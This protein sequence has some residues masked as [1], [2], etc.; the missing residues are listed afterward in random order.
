MIVGM[1]GCCCCRR[2]LTP[3]RDDGLADLLGAR[4]LSE[5]RGRPDLIDRHQV[6]QSSPRNGSLHL[7]RKSHVS[8]L[9]FTSTFTVSYRVA[10]SHLADMPMAI[11][12]PSF[13]PNEKNR[14]EQPARSPSSA[15]KRSTRLSG[16]SESALGS[17][18]VISRVFSFIWH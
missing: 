15:S 17:L 14:I 1:D 5:S 4:R 2:L 6:S 10:N 16:L 18:R 3:R 13:V 9:L 12:R 11:V 8:S 7:K